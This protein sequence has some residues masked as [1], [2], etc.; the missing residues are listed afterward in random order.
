MER[1]HSET[2]ENLVT[3]HK[4]EPSVIALI[5]GGSI[6]HGFAQPSS[7]VDVCIVVNDD[8]FARRK[9]ES[10]LV[11]NNRDPKIVV[12]DGGYVDG[13]YA[14]KAFLSLV[15]EKGSDAIRYSFKDNVVLFSHDPQLEELLQRIVRFPIE[16]KSERLERFV[17]Q[18]LAWKWY[19][20]E[21]VKKQNQYL[22]YLATQKIVLFSGRIVLTA[23]H[24]LYPYHKWLLAE[25]AKAERTPEN[26]LTDV[27]TLL[28]NPSEEFVTEF[29]RRVL[30]FAGYDEKSYFWPDRFMRD[31]E[32]NWMSHEAPVDDL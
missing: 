31:S 11:Y 4:K 12:Y 21:A 17:A 6:A 5:L 10:K 24:M 19:Y 13:K 20:S 2:I 8:D 7:D 23:N 18:V 29:C 26:F 15:A 32:Q 3:L 1:H 28:H 22:L 14:N 9:A 16:K 25:L 27:Q 30:D